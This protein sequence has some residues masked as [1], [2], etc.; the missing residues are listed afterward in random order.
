MKLRV[1]SL[2]L[3][4]ALTVAPA[5]AGLFTDDEAQKK[6]KTLETRVSQL[7]ETESKQSTTMLDLQ[8][9][10][11]A[12]NAEIR[13]L[14]GQNEELAHGLQD[15]EK[16]QKDFYVDLDSRL[17][18]FEAA[19]AAAPV[20]S[21]GVSKQPE[22]VSDPGV[23]NRAYEA[24]YAFY[25]SANYQN[26]LNA[27]QDFLSKFPQSVYVPN[28]HFW[29]GQA[30][31]AL[32]DCKNAQPHYQTVVDKFEGNQK[33]PDALFGIAGCQIEDGKKAVAKKTLKQIVGNHPGTPAAEKAKK[34]L[35]E[36]K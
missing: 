16:R 12:Q 19:E 6:I 8:S 14:R 5:Y 23:E 18:K 15:A 27:F 29:M 22:A 9:Q 33:V 7:E 3:Y 34:L 30:Y 28:S 25:K 32:K 36:L 13:R 26:A 10:I 31:V 2:A 1:L 4:C 21:G 11:E 35:G 17:R 24:A 20:Q